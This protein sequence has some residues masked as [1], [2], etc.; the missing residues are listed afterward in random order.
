MHLPTISKLVDGL[1]AYLTGLITLRNLHGTIISGTAC[2]NPKA[3]IFPHSKGLRS[4]VLLLSL[5]HS[6]PS[7]SSYR[8]CPKSISDALHI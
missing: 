8:S 1:F 2:A 6:E 7:L 3:F 5:I 4:Y